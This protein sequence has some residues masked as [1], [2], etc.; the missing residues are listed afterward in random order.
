MIEPTTMIPTM[1][2]VATPAAVMNGMP[3][4]RQPEDGDHHGSTGKHHG[5][6][7]GGHG[8]ACRLFDLETV[9]EELTVPGDQEQRV[10]DAHTEPDHRGHLGAK[11]GMSMR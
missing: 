8:S 4:H 7:R 11:L 6:T 2:E 3:G 5:E 10:I 9:G 1:I